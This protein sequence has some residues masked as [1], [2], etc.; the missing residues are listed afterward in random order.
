MRAR[1][2]KSCSRAFVCAALV[3]YSTWPSAQPTA[4]D[5][6]LALQT[7]AAISHWV[8]LDFELEPG[9]SLTLVVTLEL[10]VPQESPRRI[11]APLRLRLAIALPAASVVADATREKLP[12]LDLAGAQ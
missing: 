9:E 6:A 5:E 2:K 4:A 11:A 12:P 3:L 7:S 1:R 10:S 8:P